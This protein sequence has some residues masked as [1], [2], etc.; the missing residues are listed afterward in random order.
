MT[1][2]STYIKRV[3]KKLKLTQAELANKLG[4]NRVQITKYETKRTMPSGDIILKLRLL[5][6]G[7]DNNAKKNE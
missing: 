5:E 2:S 6:K 7:L 3:R 4:L 1:K